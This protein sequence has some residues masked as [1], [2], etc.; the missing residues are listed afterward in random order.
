MAK[1]IRELK[2]RKGQREREFKDEQNQKRGIIRALFY[3]SGSIQFLA[4][5]PIGQ[6]AVLPLD[7]RI[8]TTDNSSTPPSPLD[9]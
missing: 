7:P 8:T 6:R 9:S 3:R 1:K 2:S 4:E 5:G